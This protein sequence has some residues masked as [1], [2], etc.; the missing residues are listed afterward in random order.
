MSKHVE[1]EV[2]FKATNGEVS[3]TS[4]ATSDLNRKCDAGEN[5]T[6]EESRRWRQGGLRCA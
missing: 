5:R 2:E 1:I 6:Q 4:D 3:N